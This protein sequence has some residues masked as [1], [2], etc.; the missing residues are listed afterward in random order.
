MLLD[1]LPGEWEAAILRICKVGE[2]EVSDSAGCGV[3]L[4]GKV[5]YGK[6]GSRVE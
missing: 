1:S 4:K 3:G 2:R 6:Q 5:E